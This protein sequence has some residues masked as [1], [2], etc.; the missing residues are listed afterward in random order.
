MG[1]L[2][3]STT[4]PAVARFLRDETRPQRQDCPA[5]AVCC[6]LV[7]GTLWQIHR[8]WAV[9]VRD[10]A[11][12]CPRCAGDLAEWLQSLTAAERLAAGWRRLPLGVRAVL[13]LVLLLL[14][15]RAEWTAVTVGRQ[16]WLVGPTG[17]WY[18]L[19][20]PFDTVDRARAAARR[21]GGYLATIG[22]PSELD[23]LDATFGGQLPA[24]APAWL[25]LREVGREGNWEWETGE[26]FTFHPWAPGH[27]FPAEDER[28]R[29]A[30]LLQRE[31]HAFSLPARPGEPPERNA[32]LFERDG[33]P[34]GRFTRGE[35]LALCYLVAGL[36]LLLN[37]GRVRAARRRFY[38]RWQEYEP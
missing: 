11:R 9:E 21:S 1:R 33:R 4:P 23:W 27:P 3:P 26:P 32:A 30:A 6:G 19:A 36:L 28:L 38:R 8:R 24:G 15:V 13:A 25:G 16:D 31:M 10:H 34:V 37:V 17:H 7:D 18:Q 12:A 22:D 5:P 14:A 35:L 20:G 29:V 2:V